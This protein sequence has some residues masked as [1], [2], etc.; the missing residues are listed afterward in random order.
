[1]PGFD[2][3]G[4]A[5]AGELNRRGSYA[6]PF[7]GNVP[8]ID[9]VATDENQQS[10]AYIQVKTKRGP[11]GSWQVSLRNGWRFPRTSVAY[12]SITAISTLLRRP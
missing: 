8:G 10:M 9:I 6:S 7:S 3:T 4:R 12:A 5:G 11:G 2:R 1:M